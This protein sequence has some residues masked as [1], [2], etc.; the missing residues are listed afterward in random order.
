MAVILGMGH[1]HKYHGVIKVISERSVGDNL[2]WRQEERA[3]VGWTG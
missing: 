3:G 2:S 1:K